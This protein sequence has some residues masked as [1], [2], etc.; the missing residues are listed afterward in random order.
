GGGWVDYD[1]LN[2]STGQVAP[3]TSFVVPVT[4]DLVLGCGI[5]KTVQ[6]H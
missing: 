6:R 3:K 4:D 1:F 5:Y 2:P